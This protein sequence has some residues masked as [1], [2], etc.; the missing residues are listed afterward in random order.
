MSV[1]NKVDTVTQNFLAPMV[2]DTVLGSN[3]GFTRIVGKAERF[4]GAQ[5]EIPV[6]VA[7]NNE[8]G[9][10]DGYDTLSITSA[11]T[12]VKMTFDPKFVE[13][14]VVLAKT[15]L[16]KN[17]TD[18]KKL[19]L[20]EIEMASTAGDLADDLGTQF[21]DDGTGNGSKD[22]LGLAALID[23]GTTVATIG[24]QSRSTYTSL[25]STVTA[26]GGTLSLEKMATLYNSVTSGSNKPSVGLTTETVFSLYEQLLEPAQ[27]EMKDVS[28]VKGGLVGGAG[29]TG[30][31]YKGF[32]ILADEKCTS[33]YLYFVNEDTIKFK[34]IDYPDSKPV[35]FKMTDIKGNPYSSIKGLGF[36]WT[37]WVKPANMEAMIG[38]IVFA[39][40]MITTNPR[41]N[42]VLTGVTSV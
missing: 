25:A 18:E 13:K 37:D 8:G 16:A 34:A 24:G 2:V 35:N 9:S 19:D 23:D 31:Y 40:N 42:G 6:K 21:Y 5:E 30:L 14:P 1:S 3:V 12:R 39:G 7:K 20:M 15:E 27:R 29:Y 28:L 4:R 41:F 38:R 26:S 11:D 10:F 22:I 33:G 36:H 32:P 17:R